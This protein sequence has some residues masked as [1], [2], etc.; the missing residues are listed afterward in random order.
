MI[1]DLSQ[2]VDLGGT[3]VVAVIAFY[4]FVQIFRFKKNS[5]GY[6]KGSLEQLK[7]MNTNHLNSIERVIGEG[8]RD[9]VRAIS[10]GNQRIV[11]LLGEIKGNLNK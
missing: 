2:L 1:P 10:D 3:V 9:I 5:N 6:D 8:N 11:E 7:L 4:S